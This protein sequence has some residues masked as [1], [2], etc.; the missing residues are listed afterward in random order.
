MKCCTL[1]ENTALLLSP[2]VRAIFQQD[3]WIIKRFDQCYYFSAIIHSLIARK[4]LVLICVVQDKM[5]LS[6]ISFMW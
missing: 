4:N 2:S 5:K 6:Q 3:C 1:S